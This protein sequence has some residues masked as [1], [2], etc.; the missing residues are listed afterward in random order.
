MKKIYILMI[1]ILLG[2]IAKGQWQQCTSPSFQV[3]S[4]AVKDTNLFL[5][6]YNS[7]VYISQDYGVT[8]LSRNNGLVNNGISH[9]A[10]NE[11]Y[12]LA[13]QNHGILNSITSS[14]N[15]NGLTWI[16]SPSDY[17]YFLRVNGLHIMKIGFISES[18]GFDVSVTNLNFYADFNRTHL[19]DDPRFVAIC[20]N[21][22]Y[23]GFL[24]T[25]NNSFEIKKYNKNDSTWKHSFSTSDLKD[26][27]AIDSNLYSITSNGIYRLNSID[28]NWSLLVSDTTLTGALIKFENKL[29]A[30]TKNGVSYCNLDGT[31]WYEIN[32]GMQNKKVNSLAINGNYI[33]ASTYNNGIWKLP[34]SLI[35]G[36]NENLQNTQLH[37]FPNPATNT[38]TLNLS[39]QQG[40]QNATVSIYDI[41]G[42]QLLQQSITEAQTQIDI[43]SFAK[44]IYIVKLQTDKEILQ[45]K[46]V[47]E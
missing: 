40:L 43:S 47:K 41:Q 29:I 11:N 25:W 31:S 42:K 23:I 37:L 2:G 16:S 34:L 8:W 28:T 13:T 46:F 6:T 5:A 7:G 9:F 18:V 32:S 26:L 19:D 12:F 35:V 4:L 38:L 45:S 44:G 20:N 22:L 10:V 21:D 15:D 33:F 30:A 39:Q 1:A 3:N 36:I 24:K 27:I 17:L 14:S